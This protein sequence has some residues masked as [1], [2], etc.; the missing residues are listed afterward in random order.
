[1]FK[2]IHKNHIHKDPHT[3]ALVIYYNISD[4]VLGFLLI[5]LVAFFI[6]NYLE[7]SFH[8]AATDYAVTS[9]HKFPSRLYK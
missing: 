5:V 8:T 3:K 6:Y 1:M 4:I 7:T 2:F 9:N